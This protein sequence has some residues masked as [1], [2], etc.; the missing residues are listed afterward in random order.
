MKQIFRP[1]LILGF[2]ILIGF[3]IGFVVGARW[4]SSTASVSLSLFNSTSGPISSVRI[5]HEH[6]IE[7]VGDIPPSQTRTATFVARGE[8]SYS[9][10]VTFADGSTVE[11]GPQYAESG[12]RVTERISDRTIEPDFHAY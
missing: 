10:S 8:T 9:L 2:G 5:T 12:Y 11:R 1:L 4:G 7:L 6:G 3:V